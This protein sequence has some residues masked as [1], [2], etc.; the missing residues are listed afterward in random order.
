MVIDHFLVKGK[1]EEVL[2]NIY[3]VFIEDKYDRAMLF[4]RYQEYYES[5]F[6]EIRNKNFT[7]EEYMKIYSQKNESPYFTYPDDWSGFNMPS[8]ILLEALKKFSL[9]PNG[10]DDIMASIVEYCQKSISFK[11]ENNK[12]WYLI[13]IDKETNTETMHHEIAHGLYYTNIEYKKEMD[14]IINSFSSDEYK[15]FEKELEEL[16]YVA[17]PKII[18][19]EIQAYLSSEPYH[20]FDKTICKK[21]QKSFENIFNRYYN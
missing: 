14:E 6:V 11:S 16:G 10:Y 15:S 3:A 12:R 13:G 8:H 4:C 17:D 1:V 18:Y 2:S 20:D 7:L 9:Y 21:Y 19:D 5:P